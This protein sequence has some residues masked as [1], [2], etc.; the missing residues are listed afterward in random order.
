[1]HSK[2]V[3]NMSVLHGGSFKSFVFFKKNLLLS[4]HFSTFEPDLSGVGQKTL[5]HGS[6]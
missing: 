3:L 1:M 5:S 4:Q 6:P 2:K